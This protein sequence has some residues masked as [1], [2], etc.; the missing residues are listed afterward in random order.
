MAD[1]NNYKV[2]P[3]SDEQR[4]NI[5]RRSAY[6]LPTRPTE[7]GM[8]PNEIKR[9][10]FGY[11]TESNNS[12]MG[13]INRIVDEVNQ[14]LDAEE[15]ALKEHEEAA[16]KRHDE[17]VKEEAERFN[18]HKEAFEQ[19]VTNFNAHTGNKNNPHEV[20]KAQVGLGSVDNTADKDKPVSTATKQALH[21][22]NEGTNLDGATSHP[23][24]RKL[25]QEAVNEH[26]EELEAHNNSQDE[27]NCHP[28]LQGKINTE[29][30]D[31]KKAVENLSKSTD[32][33]L[34]NKVNYSDIQDNLT[35]S[36]A[37]KPLSAKQGKELNSK[38]GALSEN[39]TKNTI[40]SVSW[41]STNY[42]LTITD[43]EGNVQNIDLPMESVI[44]DA[45]YSSST[46][47]ITFTLVNGKT[48][49][50]DASDLVDTYTA[51]GSTLTL[52]GKKFKIA[53]AI[54]A[55]LEAVEKNPGCLPVMVDI[56]DVAPSA[57]T[58]DVV[59]SYQFS[60]TSLG[61]SRNIVVGNLCL[62]KF[63]TANASGQKWAVCK[64]TNVESTDAVI[65]R[66]LDFI[67]G[68]VGAKGETGVGIK[69]ISAAGKDSLGGNIYTITYTDDTT[70]QFV[71]PKGEDG[72]GISTITS[73]GQ[74]ANGGNQYLVNLTNGQS[75][76]FTAP[77]GDNAL[78]YYKEGQQVWLYGT[79]GEFIET[80]ES[81]SLDCFNR[82]PKVGEVFSFEAK[83][84]YIGIDGGGLSVEGDAVYL[85]YA[86][87][88]ALSDTTA[89]IE[90]LDIQSLDG[91]AA[92]MVDRQISYDAAPVKGN[93]YT[94]SRSYFN[95]FPGL[96]DV[97][98]IIGL[99]ANNNLYLLL[100]KVTSLY[101][102]SDSSLTE[103]QIL[104]V[105][106]YGGVT[107]VNGE[108]GAI[109]NV[110][111]DNTNEVAIGNQAEAVNYGVA[112]GY[113]TN[114]TN[115]SVHIGSPAFLA[116][117]DQF[118][119]KS[120]GSVAIGPDANIDANSD[121]SVGIGFAAT[122]KNAPNAVQLGSGEN[123]TEGTL[124]FRDYTLVNDAGIIPLARTPLLY[125]GSPLA[126]NY[127]VSGALNG[128]VANAL[129]FNRNPKVG[130]TFRAPVYMDGF[131]AIRSCYCVVE[132]TSSSTVVARIIQNITNGAGV[133]IM[134]TTIVNLL[135]GTTL[136]NVTLDLPPSAF[137]HISDDGTATIA[138]KSQIL[139]M[140]NRYLSAR[141]CLPGANAATT[142]KHP[143]T[144]SQSTNLII[145]IYAPDTTES[146]W[147]THIGIVYRSGSSPTLT[148]T[149]V[150]PATIIGPFGQ[151]S[152]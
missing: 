75:Y 116:D 8:K 143:A 40:K 12:V 59:Y 103:Y 70:T 32:T 30:T 51:D 37:Q 136:I 58:D 120:Q 21:D 144:G 147:G 151:I 94:I 68:A 111:K 83:A 87:I 150:Q 107:S 14:S 108:T 95:R 4:M 105:Y 23:E 131:G 53:D 56:P 62:A 80:P 69:S 63:S 1:Q 78:R 73:N 81:L 102:S 46:K 146:T 61:D 60:A 31:R 55:R 123:S 25:I 64:I 85:V 121:Y 125:T 138:T 6:T 5:Q 11:V 45:S 48:I 19:H 43:N 86:K 99:D 38:I 126:S 137:W 129:D 140:I 92:L 90:Y 115:A 79:T 35:S 122:V 67:D 91:A 17:H 98:Q 127:C 15:Q 7:Q 13:E 114:A 28:Y 82:T 118:G 10:F 2:K 34:A 88:T 149:A 104:S 66:A 54:I 65:I 24:L 52:E 9:A 145:G 22:H 74:D 133:P 18:Q 29:I 93:T 42:I 72:V 26:N 84:C 57:F 141:G 128:I 41:D 47:K 44:K 110:V 49:S 117:N 39:L 20:T 16:S 119:A 97:F 77:K 101:P 135:V 27:A 130:E 3:I 132:L 139:Y 76:G 33:S 109:T 96:W 89:S 36:D 134:N 71:A 142:L 50:I 113:Q 124:Q 152:A 148:L 100:C 106:A 112:I